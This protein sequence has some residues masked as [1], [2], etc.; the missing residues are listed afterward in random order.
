MGVNIDI[1]KLIEAYKPERVV[2]FG[3]RARGR[4]RE[5]SDFDLLI[6]K[7]GVGN[8]R[9]HDRHVE[10]LQYLPEDEAIDALVYTPGE[11]RKRLYLGDP[12]I[13][14]VFREGKVL[15]EK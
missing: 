3:S 12:F 4:G 13:E 11:I 7:E 14:S 2:L 15:Y 5:G 6:I 9:R 10:V 8:I 1:G